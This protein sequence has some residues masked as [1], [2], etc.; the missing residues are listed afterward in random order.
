MYT[1]FC[2]MRKRK[3]SC[4]PLSPLK[5]VGDSSAYGWL[6]Q[7]FLRVFSSPFRGAWGCLL[8]V[9]LSCCSGHAARGGN[10]LRCRV[11]EVED[12]YGY[13]VLHGADTLIYQPFIPAV[14]GRLPFATKAE[15]LAAGR[16]VCCKL[17]DGQLPALSR[18]E[19]K[20]C[21]TD[22][23]ACHDKVQCLTN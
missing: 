4:T 23:S 8:A 17:A 19:V 22:T 12:G 5:G 15:A 20:S 3:C 2:P 13:V 18:E 9:F 21:L 7:L 10:E 6:K 16:L 1:N 14:S 11:M